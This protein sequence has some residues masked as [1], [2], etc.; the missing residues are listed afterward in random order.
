MKKTLM[1]QDAYVKRVD[2]MTED[3]IKRI[4]ELTAISREREL[5]DDE[6]KERELLRAE[7]IKQFRARMR[8]VLDNVE[9]VD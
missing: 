2:I 8:S 6:Q 5:T 3:L 7:Y 1:L 9:I 4:N